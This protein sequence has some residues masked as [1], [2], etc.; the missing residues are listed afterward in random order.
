MNTSASTNRTHDNTTITPRANAIGFRRRIMVGA[1]LVMGIT[2]T[3]LALAATSHADVGAPPTYPGVTV[4]APAPAAPWMSMTDG[5]GTYRHLHCGFP[6][7]QGT[8]QCWYS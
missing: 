4:T 7:W 6:G 2:A 3:A 8:F 1:V 5:L